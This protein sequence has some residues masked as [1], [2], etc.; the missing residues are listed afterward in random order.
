MPVQSFSITITVDPAIKYQRFEGWG[1]SL[2]WWAEQ[3]GKWSE[4]NRTAL[5]GVI[6]DPDT[7]L[8]YNCF[9]YNI[10]GG[11]QPGHTHLSQERAVPGFK[12]SEN[13]TYDWTADP[14]QRNLLLGIASRGK[15][16]IFEAFSNS[17]PWWMTISG[18]ASGN[19]NGADNLK[20]AYFT[21]FAEYL[22]TVVKHYK[23]S[24]GITFRTVEPFNEP[25]SGY[26]KING[27]QEGCGFKSRQSQMVKE[28]GKQLVSKG[29][30]PQT[31]IS[32]ADET[33]MEHTIT[34][35]KSYDDS[36]FS[37]ISQINT[38]SY[39]GWKF[40]KSVDSL[41]KAHKKILW[42]SES[43]PID[44]SDTDPSDIAMWMSNVIIQDLRTM[45]ANAWVDWQVGDPVGNWMTIQLDHSRETFT[46]TKRYYMHAAFSRF[47]RPGSQ[48][49]N[50]SDTNSIAALDSTTG[51]LTIVLRNN[52][53]SDTKYSID[54]SR[55]KSI[56]T[57]A[58]VYRFTLP[59]SL[60]QETDISVSNKLISFTAPKLTITSCIIPTSSTSIRMC[61]P[62]S[63]AE[64]P[65]NIITF[66]SG[67]RLRFPDNF[68]TPFTLSV[69]NSQ[70]MVII[71]RK[72][73]TEHTKKG[74]VIN[75]RLFADGMYIINIKNDN[76]ACQFRCIFRQ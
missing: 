18:C 4:K 3:A 40:R 54:L 57:S 21:A 27:G 68:K 2:C 74:L 16:L 65:A 76:T 55:F 30:F 69:Y 23:D 45:K 32:A 46:Y 35:F 33:S 61:S 64:N 73:I 50:S 43:G 75:D 52:A 26:W 42:Q 53:D 59:G 37:F 15:N 67:K 66:S 44:K 63:H 7:G 11:D 48:I 39:S 13:G 31:S 17:P 36:A 10:G 5:I 38:H 70:G 29:L 25:S 58:K 47:I 49:I 72:E 14:N 6:V 56:G 9:R 24:W 8:G 1:T 41:A 19:T 51:N 60:K 28:L 12:T 34:A 22:A 71:A 20:P 62:L